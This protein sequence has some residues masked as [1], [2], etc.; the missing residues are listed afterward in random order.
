MTSPYVY[1]AAV[2]PAQIRRVVADLGLGQLVVVS[3]PPRTTEPPAPGQPMVLLTP[4][5]DLPAAAVDDLKTALAQRG[6]VLGPDTEQGVVT[7]LGR[8]PVP[9]PIPEGL[10]DDKPP[11]LEG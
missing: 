11:A 1:P 4:H 2:S 6:L 10:L 8:G 3:T 5:P 7:V 9:E